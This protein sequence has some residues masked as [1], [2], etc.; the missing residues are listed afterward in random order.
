MLTIEQVRHLLAE[1]NLREVARAS[2]LHYN[3][4]YRVANGTTRPSY[5]TVKKLSDHL[6]G[7]AA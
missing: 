5:E 7:E 6:T 1:R 4:V 2:D 3:I